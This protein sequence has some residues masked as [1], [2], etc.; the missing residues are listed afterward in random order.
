[1]AE[2]NDSAKKKIKRPTAQKRELQNEKRRL[3]NKAFKSR[4]NTAINAFKSSA[5]AKD[6][7][8]L[9]ETLNAVYSLM[10]KGVKTGVYK[11]NKAARV[12]SRLYRMAQ[13]KAS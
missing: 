7:P 9:N 1:M 5:V 3:R 11:I 12:K 8:K 6:A 10:D 2:Q 4:V 13:P